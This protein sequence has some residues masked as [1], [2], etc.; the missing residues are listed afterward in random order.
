MSEI[1]KKSGLIVKLSIVLFVALFACILLSSAVTQGSGVRGEGSVAELE[2]GCYI[3]QKQGTAFGGT[4][5]I[6][7]IKEVIPV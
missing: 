2:L 5:E 4:D 7:V 1:R 3:G 6:R